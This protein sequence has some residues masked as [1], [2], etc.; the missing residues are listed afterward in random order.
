MS[1]KISENF[2]EFKQFIISFPL[3]IQ[4]QFGLSEL[5]S[6]KKN[7]ARG[8][9]EQKILYKSDALISLHLDAETIEVKT[10]C[11]KKINN[12]IFHV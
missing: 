5:F 10:K 7:L 12:E 6:G 1:Q 4:Q 2:K 8:Q 9:H 3:N 11:K